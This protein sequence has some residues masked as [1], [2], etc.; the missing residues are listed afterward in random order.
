MPAPILPLLLL[1]ASPR[2]HDDPRGLLPVTPPPVSARQSP[3]TDIPARPLTLP[4]LVDIALCRNPQTAAAWA[5]ARAA[6]ADVGIARS[7]YLPSVDVAIGP[8][9]TRSDSFQSTGFIDANGNFVSGSSALT[10]VNSS[11]RLAL[12]YLVFDGGGRRAQVDAATARQRAALAD[13]ADNAQ[14]VV[15]A[16]VTA[17]NSLAAN[18]AVEA[19]NIANV[20]FARQSRDLAAGRQRAGVAT[21]ADRLQAET[22]L[23]QAELTLIQTRGSVATSAA[24]LAVAVGLPPTQPLTL[25]PSAP[26]PGADL[27]RSGAQGL[28]AEAERLRPDLASARAQVDAAAANV[29]SAQSLGRPSL[30]TSVTNGLSAIDRTVDRNVVSAGVSL[31]IPIFSGWNTRYQIAGARARLDQQAA[32]AEQARQQAGLDVYSNFIALDNALASLTTARTL[33]ESATLAA[34]LAQ[35]RYRAGVGTFADLLNAQSALASARQQQV[36]SEFNVRTANANLARA[37]GTI[38]D[39]IDA[40][41]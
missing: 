38:G 6:A 4:D 1:L 11:A 13:Y 34:D 23:A 32:L 9:L 29:R 2:S 10:Q 39:A 21:G 27:L 30:S 15:L 41:R 17:W 25:A 35:G 5:N 7:G 28:I 12:N 3:C 37:V 24:Q 26:L 18:R 31:S 33:I 19:A 36:Q 8:T 22:S 40:Q 20:T 14:A 16:T